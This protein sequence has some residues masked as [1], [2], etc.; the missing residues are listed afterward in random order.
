MLSGTVSKKL[1]KH[2]VCLL[3]AFCTM[4]GLGHLYWHQ[5]GWAEVKSIRHCLSWDRECRRTEAGSGQV[6]RRMYARQRCMEVQ[7]RGS[8]RTIWKTR[9]VWFCWRGVG[10]DIL[11]LLAGI[12][13]RCWEYRGKRL[14]LY[15]EAVESLR[16]SEQESALEIWIL[17]YQAG[18]VV[19]SQVVITLGK[20]GGKKGR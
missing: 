6:R 13:L 1:G 16:A 4:R 15:S 12:D 14:R 19:V 20:K 17:L 18:C 7:K 3:R 11:K 9:V 10:S 8:S 5:W 2:S